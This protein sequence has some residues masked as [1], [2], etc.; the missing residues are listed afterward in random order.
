MLAQREMAKK[1]VKGGCHNA[2][3]VSMSKRWIVGEISGQMTADE[4]AEKFMQVS[5]IGCDWL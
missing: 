5:G 2:H 1:M 4:Y 3:C